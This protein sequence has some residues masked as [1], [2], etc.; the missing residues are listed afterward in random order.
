LRALRRRQRGINPAVVGSVLLLAACGASSAISASPTTPTPAIQPS[1]CDLLSDA[2]V[3]AAFTV[4]T[5][6]ASASPSTS[7]KPTP[8]PVLTHIYSVEK[9]ALSGTKTV[10][11]CIWSSDSGAQ[12]IALVIPDTKLTQLAAYTSG[13]TQVGPA[14]V[15]EGDG[16]GF[17]S[18]QHGSGVIALTLVLDTDPATRTAQLADLAR[19]ASGA[20]VPT[21]S[22]GAL[23]SAAA[24]SSGAAASG[25]G[26]VVK[27]QTAAVKD[28]QN[29]QLQFSPTSVA[30]KAGAVLEWD[31]TGQIVHN[32]TFDAY[33]TI[34]SDTMSGGDTFQ[35]KFLQPGTYQFHCTFHPG[36]QGQV[37]V[38]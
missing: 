35:V 25:P 24:T 12:I 11:Q 30:V 9:M 17:I 19:A 34:S 2:T 15:Q 27:G 8:T 23:P 22:A 36:M 14:Y 10:G 31:N 37:T 7:T 32:V 3:A 29:D 4:A 26:T 13:A 33:P 5:G 16:R 38:Q 6:A 28:K 18:I 20:A 21:V 1:A